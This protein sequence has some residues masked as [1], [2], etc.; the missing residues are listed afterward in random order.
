[1]ARILHLISSN[2]R[3]GAEVFAC[4]LA[5]HLRGVGHEV[6]VMAVAPSAGGEVL[7]C[8][9]AGASRSDPRGIAAA[10]A[11]ARW[12]DVVVSFGSTSLI[13]G[14][15]CA[16]VARRPFVYRNIGDPGVWGA[17]RL[18]GLRIGAPVR[19]AAAV[20]ALYP[21]A[22]DTLVERY[23]L[24]AGRVRIIPRGVPADRFA[25]A[26]TEGREVARKRL[27]LE[28]TG[29][30]LAYV[31]AL[32]PEKDPLLALDVL[33]RLPDDV[34]LVMA[35]GGPM[36]D[37]VRA[38]A[39]RFGDRAVVL[40]RVSDVRDVL[41]AA[42]VLVL[43]SRTEGIP[44]VVI[45]AGLSGVAT[46]ATTVGGVPYVIDDGVTG[47]LVPLDAPVEFADAVADALAHHV[48]MGE[49]AHRKCEAEYSMASVGAAWEEVHE[50]L[51]GGRGNHGRAHVDTGT[52]SVLQIVAST[53]R[54]GAEVFANQLG[55][56][57]DARGWRHRTVSVE[58]SVGRPD[59]PFDVLGGGRFH[60]GTL[61]ALAR[62]A[63]RHDVLVAHGSSSLLPTMLVATAARR[64]F[65]YRNI[66][67]PRHWGDVPLADLRI[68]LALRRADVV[69]ALSA[70]ARAWLARQYDVDEHRIAV[71]PNG[72]DVRA[73]ERA[74]DTTR[75]AARRRLDV[76]AD[77]EVLGYLGS[78]SSEKRPDWAVRATAARPGAILLVGGAGPMRTELEQLA[79]DLAPDRVR[80]V[81]VLDDTRD[82]YA[83]IDALLLPSLTEGMPAVAIEAGLSGVRTIATD[84]GAVREVVL[85]HDTGVIVDAAAL[86]DF[87]SAVRDADLR[88]RVPEAA[89]RA[90]A[91]QF[92]MDRVADMWVTELE[93][94]R[95]ERGR[96][97][98]RD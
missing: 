2:E 61:A 94:L 49:A 15:L 50:S 71:I 88:E 20:V 65:A 53:Q 41:S 58:R 87:T 55:E 33:G 80:F 22:K 38:A 34:G 5:D 4:E 29:R 37:E 81:G 25:P 67:D 75:R 47:R 9:I 66:G 19:S 30:W 45:E 85:D 74:D 26:D 17:T 72:V 89:A 13:T 63:R 76:P 14:A 10:V 35:G 90:L 12:S 18:A 40:G 48:E 82:F 31:G 84:V 23:H 11:A 27:G 83:A 24:D 78:L 77:A 39:A 60:P 36:E 59:L 93:R 54:R 69:V 32:S 97:R 86:G 70:P 44:G 28:P 68:G 91:E 92:G 98:R 42:D 3:R 62:S 73:V 6:R 96:G 51:L 56:A 57:L 8:E 7:D 16:R 95:R 64:P 52:P 79:A 1:M 43:T 46:V 21:G